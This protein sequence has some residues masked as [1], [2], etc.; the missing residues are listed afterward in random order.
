MVLV[1][2][3]SAFEFGPWRAMA[4]AR[5]KVSR[6]ENLKRSVRLKSTLRNSFYLLFMAKDQLQ[7]STP[8]HE[9]N[10]IY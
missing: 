4:P 7:R 6:L 1:S 5:A 8:A 2:M 9:M 10:W 3:R